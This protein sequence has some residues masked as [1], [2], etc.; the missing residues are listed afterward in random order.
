[1]TEHKAAWRFAI[2][3]GGTFT[4]VVATTPDGRLVTDKL[5]SENPEHY[6]DAASEAVRRLMRQHGEG[7]IAELRIGTTVATNALLERKGERLAL[8]ITKGFGDALRIGTQARPEIFARHIVLPEQL[9]ARVVEVAERVGVDGEVLLALDEDA[10]RCDFEALREDGF[11]AIAIV[12]MHGWKYRDH[13][14]RLA[15]IAR[16]I[17]FAQVSVS[18][19]VA[20]LIK[21]VP[22]GDTTVV[23]AY[24]SPVLRRYTD[25]LRAALPDAD[26][27]RFMQSNGGLAEVGAFRGKDAILSGPAGGVVGM[28][29]AS[30][31]LG[32]SKLIGF[33][34]GG[35]STDVA[36]YAGEYELTGDSVVA[37]V[38]VAAPMMQ[39]H[40][41]AAGG[42]SICSFDGARFR[43]GPES[44][45]ANPGPACYRKGGPLT[46]TDCNLFLGRIDPA[47]FPSV[48]GPD[49]GQPLDPAASRALL[50]DIAAAL[51]EPKPLE[52]IAEGFLAI[53]VDN[54]ANAIRKISVARGH[55]V[56]TYALACFGGAGGQHACKV[57]DELGI[58]TVLVHPL[59]GILSAYG[60]GLAPVKAIREVSL[61]KP[62]TSDFSSN[63]AALQEEALA[64]LVEQGIA[65][66]AITIESR[67]RLRFKGSDSMLTV[68]VGERE[69]M[70]EAFRLLHRQRFGYSDAEAPIIV[71]ALSVEAS[72]ISG[73]LATAQADPVDIAGVASGTWR[74]L[75]RA[76]LGEG[77]EVPGP[78][79]VVDPGSTTVV[80]PGWQARLE[81]EGTLVLTRTEKLERDRAVGTQ[82]DPVRLEIFNNLFM[83]IAEE[84]GV[85]LQSTATSVN[86]KERLDFS[87]ALFDHTG[88]LIA[89]APHIPV[90]L[91]SMGDSIARV[92]EQRGRQADGRGFRRGD[93]YVLNDP[94]RGGTHLPDIT[95][96]V[97]V[98]YDETSKEP[99]AFV[100]AR[101]HH[102][103]IGGIAPGSMPPESRT[104]EEEGVLIDN[105]LMV[106]EGTFRE[107]AVREALADA[108]H[109]ARN[110]SRNISDLRAQLAA[111]TRGAELLQ[112]AARDQG[113]EVVSAYMSHV[114]A[115]AEESV[116][117]L[118][119]R[120][121]DGEFAYEMDNG[122]IVKVAIRIDSATR[123]AVFDFTGT[124]EQQD[125]NFNAPR[126]IT[127][128]A[129][130]YVLRTL[131][132]DRIPMNDG[133]LR[134]VELIVPEGSMLNPHPGAAVVAGNVETSQ[135]VTDTLFAATGRLAPSQGTMNNFTFGNEAHQY[136]ETI[137]GGSGA[138]PDH[139]GTSAVQTHMTNSRL[140]DP[141]I[142][143]TRLPVRLESFAIRRGS[144]GKGAHQGGDGV[145]R[146]VTFL[147]EMRGDMLA[148]RREVPPRGICGGGDAAPGRN[149]VERADGSREELTATASAQMK[150]GDTF[151]ILTPGGGGFGE[152]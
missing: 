106:D 79:L 39:I 55:D 40:T 114:L 105:L 20:P 72:G 29:A 65:R 35:T 68:D 137:C 51:P 118:L 32:H 75:A 108:R 73:G 17:G 148:N 18:H 5:L 56:T 97:P 67:A 147:E 117:R 9:P 50:E 38:R 116:R 132:D 121:D 33:D 143:E 47:F 3:R 57:A 25:N 81:R 21:L 84:M 10:A 37:G 53:A 85:V 45:G 44:A 52:D 92:V 28:V 16:D 64:A 7:P 144:G 22:R 63:L 131:I 27:L 43:V 129:A 70:D 141:E 149:W 110:P 78:A 30:E 6:R 83:A 151:V 93:A 13:E 66:E 69:A 146:R 19:E 71:E 34:M 95:V 48:F 104:I 109:P 122:A 124:S 77:E 139:E 90:H 14:E 74:T 86:I 107:A 115:N 41:V 58:E 136:Y 60:I 102:A 103:D 42:G 127:R 54:M 49:G 152:G 87:C 111:C 61:V 94:Y 15:K 99:D 150:P 80:E 120:L 76:D 2:D 36:H 4:D 26:R 23:D 130:L 89:N 46:V 126:S 125:N 91:G 96:I 138:G 82:V 119:G 134:P 11:D 128:A 31:P 112:G 100:A 133:C 123:S 145:E 12:L 88:A 62:L 142:L 113:A 98:F 135:V 59:A 24:L 1:M 8:A 101:G 140:T